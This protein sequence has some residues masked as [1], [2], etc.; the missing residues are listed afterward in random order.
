[1]RGRDKVFGLTELAFP[2]GKGGIHRLR[3]PNAEL[4]LGDQI[5]LR[6]R[7]RD[8]SLSLVRPEKISVLNVFEG[9]VVEVDDRGGSQVDVLIDVGQPLIARITQR[10]AHDLGIATG[11][12]VF[13]LVKAA[14]IDRHSLGLG[15]AV[16]RR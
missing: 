7:A 15:D 8:V 1:M 10:S 6:V 14:A 4:A 13:A 5:R 11:K 2:D 3:V 16:R 9:R 12:M